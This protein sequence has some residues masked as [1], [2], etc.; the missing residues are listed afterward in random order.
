M[1]D[2]NGRCEQGGMTILCDAANA[3]T[4]WAWQAAFVWNTTPEQM[5][6]NGQLLDVSMHF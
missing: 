5:I 2:I 6:V 1:K 3:V 4:T